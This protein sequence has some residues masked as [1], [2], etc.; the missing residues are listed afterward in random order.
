MQPAPARMQ[1]LHYRS[2]W[3]AGFVSLF[4]WSDL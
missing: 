1:I 3:R 4:P 2:G